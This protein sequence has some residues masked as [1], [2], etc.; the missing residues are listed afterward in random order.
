M[1]EGTGVLGRE[2]LA[3]PEHLQASWKRL[4]GRRTTPGPDGETVE[5][6]AGAAERHLTALRQ[7][8]TS[9]S[10]R[11]RSARRAW[12]A[13]GGGGERGVVI[14]CV[15]DR[16]AQGAAQRA[17]GA[18]FNPS[19]HA[20][21]YSYRQG[22]GVLHAAR[23]LIEHRDA[24]RGWV[25]RG[26]IARFFDTVPHPQLL[27]AL[28][29]RLSRG[30]LE[31]VAVMLRLPVLEGGKESVTERGLPQGS[32]LSPLLANIY[33]TPFDRAVS[34]H[35]PGAV[36]FADDFAVACA[37]PSAAGGV[38][39]T[40]EETLGVLELSLNTAKTRIVS[41]EQGFAFLGFY[42]K[43]KS[44][45]I[46]RR[47]LDDFRNHVRYLLGPGY[48]RGR[49]AALREV[50]NLVRGWRA[51]YQLGEVRRDFRTLD[52][53][54]RG[55]ADGADLETLLPTH[56]QTRPPAMGEIRRAGADPRALRRPPGD[57]PRHALGGHVR[58]R[59]AAARGNP[60]RDLPPRQRARLVPPAPA[61]LGA[62]RRQADELA[63]LPPRH[64]RGALARGRGGGVSPA[65]PRSRA[66]SP[67]PRRTKY[68]R[69]P[70]WGSPRRGT[71]LRWAWGTLRRTLRNLVW[72]DL[73]A[74]GLPL[75]PEEGGVPML[76]AALADTLEAPI[77]HF[78]LLRAIE[79]GT[80]RQP[81]PE[82]RRNLAYRVRYRRGTPHRLAWRD[83]LSEEARALVAALQGGQPYAV[84]LWGA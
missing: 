17:L 19:L 59:V 29:P 36:R 38:L 66:A 65:P 43:G 7:E 50:N 73:L 44:V 14:L 51:Y 45:R 15:R 58:L 31:L 63:A 11:P 42:F 75:G 84:W 52:D 32:P 68:T 41:F 1:D 76:A 28:S 18:A 8:L 61:S 55:A 27:R 35:G 46:D 6:F 37:S 69:A 30:A 5:G 40:A 21:A 24:G 9:G 26:D 57:K 12:L 79:R 47:N 13:K 2:D 60:R 54:L 77:A 71:D 23:K 81:H 20:S 49:A 82:L 64:L 34:R 62:A 67:S 70:C 53:W 78:C 39:E 16:V 25:V 74:E 22:L 10:Y 83:V 80:L 72:H 4:A 3:R 33:L 48:G 56:T